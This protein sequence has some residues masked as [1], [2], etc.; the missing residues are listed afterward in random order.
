[1][2][3]SLE[4]LIAIYLPYMLILEGGLVLV[5]LFYDP[6]TTLFLYSKLPESYRTW[7]WLLACLLEEIRSMAIIIAI[8]VPAEQ[9]KVLA[10]GLVRMSLEEVVRGM[11]RKRYS[12]Q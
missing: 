3:S 10:I 2:N 7:P 5:S 4:D 11:L 1:M 8:L 6:T 9:I 12:S